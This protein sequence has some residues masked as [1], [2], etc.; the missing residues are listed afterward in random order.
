MKHTIVI[1]IGTDVVDIPTMDSLSATQYSAYI[2]ESLLWV[3]HH[4]VLRVIHGDYSVATNAEQ[5]ELLIEHLR[6]VADRMRRA[7]K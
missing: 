3:D 2:E 7:G 1:D 4:D 5:V 6:G